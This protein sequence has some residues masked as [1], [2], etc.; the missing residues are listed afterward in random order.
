MTKQIDKDEETIKR[1]KPGTPPTSS[2][3]LEKW[4]EDSNNQLKE[5]K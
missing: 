1:I 5:R 3:E 2:K 4:I